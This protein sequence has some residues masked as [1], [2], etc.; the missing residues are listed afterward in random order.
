[1]YAARGI[2]INWILMMGAVL[3]AAQTKPAAWTKLPEAPQPQSRLATLS[4]PYLSDMNETSWKWKANEDTSFAVTSSRTPRESRV[5]DK[6]YLLLNGLHL[7]LALAD[8]EMTRACIDAHACR[9]GNPLM[10]SSH[11]GQLAVD[12]GFFAYAAGTSYWFKKN[13]NG[14]WWLPA[15]GGSAAHTAGLITGLLHQ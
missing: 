14:L 11:A 5:I 10:P 1:M 7:G 3:C 13:H 12:F 15:V 8:T 9:E 4:K 2:L 6:K